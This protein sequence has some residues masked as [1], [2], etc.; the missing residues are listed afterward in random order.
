MRVGTESIEDAVADDEQLQE[1]NE[2]EAVQIFYWMFLYIK[3]YT[4]PDISYVVMQMSWLLAK[5]GQKHTKVA[6]CVLR[7]VKKTKDDGITYDSSAS[8]V[9]TEAYTD[10]YW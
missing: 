7:Y 10:A 1:L 9:Q 2:V 8:E 5:S 3:T 4:S 6:T